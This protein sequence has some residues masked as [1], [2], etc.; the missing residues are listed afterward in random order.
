M[1]L[2]S[3]KMI[4][5]IAALFMAL[6]YFIPFIGLIGVIMLLIGIKQLSEYYRET[7][8]FQNAL[9]GFIFGLIGIVIAGFT[10][11]SI[12]ILF[13]VMRNFI[14][15]GFISLLISLLVLFVFFLLKAIF[16]RR[17]F[18]LIAE[19][20]GDRTFDTVGTLLL[21]GAVLTIV[22]VGLLLMFIAWVIAAIAFLSIRPKSS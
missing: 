4:S 9:Y 16:Y 5:G 20:T 11:F 2:E 18:I 21:I 13:E 6:G 10:F 19:K 1:S 8:I 12:L 3:A 14:L 7:K 15:K 22:V 17:S